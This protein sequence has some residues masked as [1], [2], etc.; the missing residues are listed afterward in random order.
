M[1][2]LVIGGSGQ[3]GRF[4]IPQL[5]EAGHDV[6]ALSRTPR[7]STRPGLEWLHGDV[8]AHMPDLPAL[9]MI[10]SLGPLNGFAEWLA[11]AKLRGKPRIVAFGSMSAASKRDSQDPAERALAQTLRNA[12]RS[13]AE[14]AVSAD[15]GWI[16][17]RPTLIYGAG[18][19]RS[20]S[21][22]ARIGARWHVFP[23]L[24]GANGLRQP[25]HAEDLASICRTAVQTDVAIG[26]S[27][28]L[29]GGERL[30]FATMLDRVRHSLATWTLPLPVPRFA[31]GSGLALAARAGLWS[32]LGAQT[33][34]RLD[35]D[36]LADD[37]PIRG[38]LGWSPRPFRPD[39]STWL[40]PA[41]L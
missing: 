28:D 29:G 12:E 11:T 36:L 33:V 40:P 27:F 23:D 1:R 21:P 22:L 35:K 18:L 16:L 15:L 34:V 19:D 8:F 38:L 3:I 2:A 9:D 32:G 13:L 20:L 25:V 39:P 41:L 37:G 26:R 30:T 6:L 17:L 31:L 24:R 10:F 5:L 4:L 14:A 7:A